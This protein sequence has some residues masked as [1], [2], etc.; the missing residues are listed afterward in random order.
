MAN[1]VISGHLLLSKENSIS[2]LAWLAIV[3]LVPVVGAVLYLLFGVNRIA[4][5]ARLLRGHDEQRVYSLE[6]DEVGN[7]SL[8]DGP[9]WAGLRRMLDAVT[10]LPLVGGNQFSLLRD[11][12]EAYPAMLNAIA[13]AQYSIA[14]TSYIFA[15]DEWGWRFV[16]ALAEAVER[17]VEVRVLIDGAG[18][19]YGWPPVTRLL[20]RR[21]IR[22]ALFLHSFLP[23]RMPYI[24][25]RNHRKLLL[26]DGR[27][28]FTG[29]IN[30]RAHH[31]GNPP[32]ARD[33]HFSV[34]GPVVSQMMM[35]FNEDWHFS[36]GERLSGEHWFPAQPSVGNAL[37][38]G[39]PDGP[40]EDFDQFRWALHAGLGQARKSVM[41]MT[42]YFVPGDGLM[43]SLRHAALRGI[44][45]D[46]LLPKQNNWPFVSWAANTRLPRLL[47]AGVRVWHTPPPFD[48]SKLM[49]VDGQWVLLGSANWDA[50]SLRLNFEFN[51]EVYDELLAADLLRHCEQ[52]R[53]AA[54]AMTVQMLD[55]RPL[56]AKLRDGAANLLSPY[57]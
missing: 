56:W 39:I 4:R 34:A 21:G 52:L 15:D 37:A 7:E 50:R 24:N 30:I 32:K 49:V 46:L 35:V 12:N 28:G 41:I 57:L 2:A 9:Q 3:W 8:P 17:G 26:V 40:D 11:G 33:L 43:T 20:R 48:H 54:S 1:V 10:L 6:L 44:E 18:Q 53:Q 47:N 5:R 27:H 25:L 14:L 16:D 45:V 31:Y 51:L 55:K 22:H 29:G 38:R 13:Q 36:T 42:P 23:W 19:Y